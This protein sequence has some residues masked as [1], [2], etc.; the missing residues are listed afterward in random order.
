M[1]NLNLIK[2]N[3]IVNAN[4]LNL[5]GYS[6]NDLGQTVNQ[7]I[8]LQVDKTTLNPSATT[9][10]NLNFNLN[11]DAPVIATPFNIS[12]SSTWTSS[13]NN[14]VYDSIGNTHNASY[15]FTKTGANAWDLNVAIDGTV[16]STTALTFDTAGKLATPALGSITVTAPAAGANLLNMTFDLSG[17]TQFANPFNINNLTQ[18]GYTAGSIVDISIT[19]GVIQ[20]KYS[21]GQVKNLAQ[22]ALAN[23]N[24]PQ[25]LAAKGDNMYTNTFASGDP[26]VGDSTMT[27]F[28]SITSSA[29]EESNVDMTK[30]LVAMIDAQRMYQ[31]NAQ[32]IK[33]EDQMMQ[34]ILSI[35]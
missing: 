23:F 30:E 34:T 17:T 28:G 12:N 14:V 1:D 6:I 33:T 27:N 7:L 31:A 15:Y 9:T 35:R 32:T 22:I 26:M 3:Y 10:G 20:G 25:G 16:Q 24:N 4:G 11:A 19:D 21:N 5:K 2:N 29:L 13:A 8:D 18:N